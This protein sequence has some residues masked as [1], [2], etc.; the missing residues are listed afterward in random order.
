[1]LYDNS[2]NSE[3]S[4]LR[5]AQLSLFYG[6]DRKPSVEMIFG[7]AVHRVLECIAK[8]LIDDV[9]DS[10]KP[11]P[12]GRKLDSNNIIAQMQL[13]ED[14]LNRYSLNA[15]ML[16]KFRELTKWLTAQDV[17]PALIPLHHNQPAAEVKFLVTDNNRYPSIEFC[18]TID[19]ISVENDVLILTDYK[20]TKS[21]Y[22]S[23]YLR[24]Y[25]LKSQ[26]PFYMW[27]I[28]N[29]GSQ[30]LPSKYIGMP[31]AG[32]I[33]GIF[34]ENGFDI[35]D[36]ETLIWNDE[37]RRQI[38]FIINHMTQQLRWVEEHHKNNLLAPKTGM[39]TGACYRCPHAHICMM[40]DT[41][42]ELRYIQSATKTTYNPLTFR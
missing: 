4:C 21:K 16:P 28:E 3:L 2:A 24:D 42:E 1:M 19:C 27:I 25:K 22:P 34:Y 38:Q 40:H 29:Y 33:R 6:V 26:L 5:K 12:F 37:H 39:A 32:R 15:L 9:S 41:P 11:I 30:F 17:V 13:I 8:G 7:S 35:R 20:C 23:D 31:L 14:A 36:G 18:G 10:N